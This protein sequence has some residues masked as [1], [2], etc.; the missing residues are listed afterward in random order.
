MDFYSNTFV[1]CFSFISLISMAQYVN[2]SDDVCEIY[3]KKS[4][5]LVSE[6]TG[7]ENKLNLRFMRAW[8]NTI[9]FPLSLAGQ[10]MSSDRKGFLF[11]WEGLMNEEELRHLIGHLILLCM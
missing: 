8:N 1:F 11:V 2:S 4:I 7:R 6:L 9:F 5:S 3:K 10:Q